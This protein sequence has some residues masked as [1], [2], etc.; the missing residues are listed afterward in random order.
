MESKLLLHREAFYG[1]FGIERGVRKPT[2]CVRIRRLKPIARSEIILMGQKCARY[3]RAELSLRVLY[4]LGPVAG[5][6]VSS[7]FSIYEVRLALEK[8]K[9]ISRE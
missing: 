6:S 4:F 3:V 9:K 1:E 5:L 7:M 2:V 8:M